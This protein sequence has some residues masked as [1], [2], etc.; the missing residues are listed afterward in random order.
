MK[1]ISTLA[2]VTLALVLIV[3]LNVAYAANSSNIKCT[4][5]CH[6]HVTVNVN[7]TGIEKGLEKIYNVLRRMLTLYNTSLRILKYLNAS[8]IKYLDNINRTLIN[9]S[10]NIYI[11]RRVVT[12]AVIGLPNVLGKVSQ[13]I[14]NTLSNLTNIDSADSPRNSSLILLG[15]LSKYC[16]DAWPQLL[17]GIPELRCFVPSWTG[18]RGPVYTVNIALISLFAGLGFLTVYSDIMR[19]IPISEAFRRRGG[20]VL[21]KTVEAG[22]YLSILPGLVHVWNI[23][24]FQNV[25]SWGTIKMFAASWILLLIIS[26]IP[27]SLPGPAI[28]PAILRVVP[29]AIFRTVYYGTLLAIF[30]MYLKLIMAIIFQIALPIA[31]LLETVPNKA[32]HNLGWTIEGAFWGLLIGTLLGAL[33]TR[34]V[35]AMWVSA[36]ALAGKAVMM[37]MTGIGGV[38]TG[39]GNY[40]SCMIFRLHCA[41]AVKLVVTSAPKIVRGVQVLTLQVTAIIFIAFLGTFTP[42]ALAIFFSWRRFTPT[43][44]LDLFIATEF[45]ISELAKDLTPE[46]RH[47]RQRFIEKLQEKIRERQL[48][49]KLRKALEEVE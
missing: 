48:E 18:P 12:R 5:I 15:K 11:I 17:I 19:G 13:N 7:T 35:A 9:I 45:G 34:I 22:I 14:G 32:I 29:T 47:A 39:L 23:I 44:W 6:C 28:L 16:P 10:E 1:R 26:L 21:V 40:L 24:L 20:A 36:G 8:V 38:L 25:V 27:L 33:M 43:A 46:A 4:C 49:R 30:L 2:L 42:C 3:M 41:V 37:I 31:V